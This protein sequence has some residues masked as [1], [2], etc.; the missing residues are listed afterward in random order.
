MGP[1]FLKFK[2]LDLQVMFF[3]LMKDN[4]DGQPRSKKKPKFY[5][6]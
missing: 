1:R 4:N 3:F 5:L 6:C 2:L